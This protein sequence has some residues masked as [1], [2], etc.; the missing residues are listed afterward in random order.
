LILLQFLLIFSLFDLYD[1]LV[2]DLCNGTSIGVSNNLELNPV[3]STYYCTFEWYPII[4]NDLIPLFCTDHYSTLTTILFLY[5]LSLL[6]LVCC[7]PVLNH[8][9]LLGMLALLVN[10][11]LLL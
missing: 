6:Y 5:W 10:V 2:L 3:F 8:L 4:G 7:S 11:W 9:T 1:V